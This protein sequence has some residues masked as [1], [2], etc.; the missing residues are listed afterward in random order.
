MATTGETIPTAERIY[1]RI[2]SLPLYSKMSEE[3][4]QDVIDAVKRVVV[5]HRVA[6]I[7]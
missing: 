5:G 6:A 7:H 4:V 1:D 2:I 3:D